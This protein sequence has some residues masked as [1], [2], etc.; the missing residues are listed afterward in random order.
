LGRLGRKRFTN[1]PIEPKKRENI[2]T[3]YP[4]P[5][6]YIISAD[7]AIGML[8]SKTRR[9]KSIVRK[10]SKRMVE[11][12]TLVL[13]QGRRVRMRVIKQKMLKQMRKNLVKSMDAMDEGSMNSVLPIRAEIPPIIISY[14]ECSFSPYT[15]QLS[16]KPIKPPSAETNMINRP[17]MDDREEVRVRC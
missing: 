5:P 4:L 8:F 11:I 3:W 1:A 9:K 13:F 7:V 14:P 15:A 12:A 16:A 10:S 17:S 6:K 2:E